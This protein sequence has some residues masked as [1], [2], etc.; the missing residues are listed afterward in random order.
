MGLM[1][2]VNAIP[3][4]GLVPFHRRPSG[5]GGQAG[6]DNETTVQAFH[7]LAIVT[8]T[9]EKSADNLCNNRSCTQ[10]EWVD[11]GIGIRANDQ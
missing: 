4:V 8:N 1:T 5:D 11:D 3:R 6:C 10:Y 7:H 2:H 9:D